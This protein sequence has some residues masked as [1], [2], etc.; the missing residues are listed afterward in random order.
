[1]VLGAGEMAELA[2]ECLAAAKGVRTAIV[3]NR[4]YERAQE[5]A[6]RYGATALHYDE[7]WVALA[8]V[9]LLICSTAAPHAIVERRAVARLARSAR[10]DRPL[11][12]LDIAVPRDVDPAVGALEQRLPLRSR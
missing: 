5:L 12:I 10:G 2:L 7:C 9:D 8:D 11:C 6:A 4:T 1:M 3:A